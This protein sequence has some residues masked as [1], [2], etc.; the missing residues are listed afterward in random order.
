MSFQSFYFNRI[1]LQVSRFDKWVISN[2]VTKSAFINILYLTISF[3]QLV[4]HSFFS[5]VQ[6]PAHTLKRQEHNFLEWS[7]FSMFKAVS[8]VKTKEKSSQS[9]VLNLC[10]VLVCVAACTSG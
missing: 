1:I 3:L 6:L 7:R 5:Y 9:H 10:S 2:K 8:D 4:E